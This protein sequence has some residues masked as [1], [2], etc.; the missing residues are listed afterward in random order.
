MSRYIDA[1]PF[2]NALKAVNKKYDT[3]TIKE[4][5]GVIEKYPNITFNEIITANN[6]YMGTVVGKHGYWDEIVREVK[7]EDGTFC[8]TELQT[9]CSCCHKEPLYSHWHNEVQSP[10]CPWC[11]AKMGEVEE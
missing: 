3:I 5:L 8:Y 9:E 10:Y 7:L 11:G 4:V 6:E 1:E 2:I